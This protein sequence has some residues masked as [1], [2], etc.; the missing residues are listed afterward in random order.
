[1]EADVATLA[2]V[3]LAL[4]Y[5]GVLAAAAAAGYVGG[6]V[7]RGLPGEQQMH[8]NTRRCADIQTP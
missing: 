8:G 5:P 6:M 4:F 7:G 3:P 2:S 1:M